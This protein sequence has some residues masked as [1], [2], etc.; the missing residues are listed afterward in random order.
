MP[1]LS[2]DLHYFNNPSLTQ[3]THTKCDLFDP[4][5]QTWFQPRCKHAHTLHTHW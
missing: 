2:S 1:N 3:E 4:E 5:D